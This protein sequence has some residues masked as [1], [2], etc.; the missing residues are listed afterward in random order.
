MRYKSCHAIAVLLQAKFDIYAAD[1]IQKNRKI[2]PKT[3]YYTKMLFLRLSSTSTVRIYQDLSSWWRGKNFARNFYPSL[4][5]T[6]EVI[7]QRMII[8]TAGRLDIF[9]ILCCFCGQIYIAKGERVHISQL[10][11]HVFPQYF[12][13][14][15]E[16]LR[17]FYDK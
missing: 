6:N 10:Y 5:I 8:R 7:Q 16:I 2:Q 13:Y 1:N 9:K 4:I 17:Y 15:I 11:F 3:P 14:V 12:I